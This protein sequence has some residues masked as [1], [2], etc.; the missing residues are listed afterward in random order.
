MNVWR[1]LQDSK[2]DP[3]A[4][5]KL[6][7]SNEML[8]EK[9]DSL[10]KSAQVNPFVPSATFLIPWKQKTVRFSDVFRGYRKGALGTNGFICFSHQLQQISNIPLTLPIIILTFNKSSSTYYTHLPSFFRLL[11]VTIITGGGK[12]YMCL[13]QGS[14]HSCI[15]EKKNIFCMN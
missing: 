5:M 2:T 10:K 3:K 11:E 9:V 7:K 8:K 15:F 6:E 14:Y 12:N 13:K 1:F 4:L